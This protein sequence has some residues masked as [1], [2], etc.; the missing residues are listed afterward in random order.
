MSKHTES[1]KYTVESLLRSPV[2]YYSAAV[3]ITGAIWVW[4]FPHW[5]LL[6]KIQTVT[7]GLLLCLWGGY[8]FYQG[9]QI[10]LY[11]RRL[12]SLS[13][14]S[15]ST[16]QVPI[17]SKQL[18]L[19]R[20]FRWRA[21]HSQRLHAINQSKN[22]HFML[23]SRL[24]R[25]ART[26]EA[27]LPPSHYL[28]RC[29]KSQ[30]RF[31]PVRP[32]P[33]IGGKPWLHGLGR[34]EEAIYLP[35]H[36]RNG[37]ILVLGTTR[38][39]KTRLASILINQDI[40]NGEGVIVLDPKGDL[41]LMRDM[42]SAAKVAN[43]L[44]D[45]CCLHAGFDACSARYNPLA[46]FGNISEVATRITTG[47]NSGNGDDVFTDFAWKY[48]NIV[49]CCL[50]DM[51]ES[52]TYQRIAFFV[53]HMNDL[54][55][56]YMHKVIYPYHVD[57]EQAIAQIKDQHDCKFDSNGEPVEPMSES[58]AMKKGIDAWVSDTLAQTQNNNKPQASDEQSQKPV[59]KTM[60]PARLLSLYDASLLDKN[61]FDKITAN[62]SPA[63]D[64][65]NQG[66]SAGLF[67][68]EQDGVYKMKEINLMDV[69]KKRKIVY[70]GLDAMSNKTVATAIGKA[71]VADLVS[72]VGMLYKQSHSDNDKPYSL[73]LHADEFS[74]V[75]TSQ[76][77]TLL[78]KAGGAGV[79]V[80]AYSQTLQDIQ[81][82]FNG[83]QA[84]AKMTEGNLNT[85]IMLRVK[86]KETAELLTH[87]L[88]EVDVTTQVQVSSVSDTPHGSDGVYFNTSNEDRV[89]TSSI[90][91]LSVNDMVSLPKGQAFVF[92]NGGELYKIRIPLPTSDPNTPKSM[93]ALMHSLNRLDHDAEAENDRQ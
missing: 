31:N 1:K 6:T 16:T 89:Q 10:S 37:H 92:V 15:M 18:Y 20:G 28:V 27:M 38:V 22:Q 61:Y 29:L 34:Y 39:G 77:V 11:P 21:H 26:I 52:I 42:Y 86:N 45:M 41:E 14:F 44:D 69:I 72:T 87:Q 35:Q 56:A 66:S 36:Q 93:P 70:I 43:R 63:L 7:M 23:P 82:G 59:P 80:V 49:A 24:Y 32:L 13:T 48:L 54:L 88:P 17:S 50:H 12:L 8:R 65:I 79:K 67:S 64:K 19:G 40:R 58:E 5:F 9:L 68:F 46:A 62:I 25:L 30:S 57:L 91:M 3:S 78:N 74:D 55:V 53:S 81:A 4:A 47:I 90:P 83:S 75:I 71:L 84:L 2:E 33:D 60:L 51:Q 85:L 73:C 76:F